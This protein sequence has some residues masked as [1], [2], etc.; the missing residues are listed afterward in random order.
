MVEKYDKF[1]IILFC[2][3]GLMNS[4]MFDNINLYELC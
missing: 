2:I 3:T 1:P 4:L